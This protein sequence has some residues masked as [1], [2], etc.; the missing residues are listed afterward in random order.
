M[1]TSYPTG[2]TADCINGKRPVDISASLIKLNCLPRVLC[3]LA[4]T[5]LISNGS[6]S[7]CLVRLNLLVL[8]VALDLILSEPKRQIKFK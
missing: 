8:N 3:R 7:I 4:D 2:I 5:C 1:H 6:I